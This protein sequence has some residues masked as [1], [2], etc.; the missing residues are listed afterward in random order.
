MSVMKLSRGGAVHFELVWSKDSGR[1]AS[2]LQREAN[3]VLPITTM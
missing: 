1:I 3:M 2:T